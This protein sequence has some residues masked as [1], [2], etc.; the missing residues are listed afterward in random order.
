V[1]TDS[2]LNDER[3]QRANIL[4]CSQTSPVFLVTHSHKNIHVLINK[5]RE[6]GGEKRKQGRTGNEIYINQHWIYAS[7]LSITP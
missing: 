1:K 7:E 5:E 2:V 6:K 4:R 3:Y